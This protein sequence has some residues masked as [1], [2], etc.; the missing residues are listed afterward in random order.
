MA[1]NQLRPQTTQDLAAVSLFDPEMTRT[2]AMAPGAERTVIP[3][4]P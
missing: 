1:L 3:V 4:T 2:W